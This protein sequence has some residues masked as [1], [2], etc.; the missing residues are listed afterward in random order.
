MARIK[1]L[2][3]GS[4]GDYRESTDEIEWV[5]LDQ[6]NCKV[7]IKANIEGMGRCY[8]KSNLGIAAS[9]IY[10]EMAGRISLN[11]AKTRLKSDYFDRI[12]AIQVLE[13]IDPKK[14]PDVVREMYRISK[15]GALWNISVPHGLSLNYV[16][17]PT[18][19][20]HF[21]DRTFDYFVEGA[22]LRENG[23]IYGWGD[24]S[25]AHSTPPEMDGVMSIHFHLRVVKTKT[26][27][28]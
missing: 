1:A 13:H 15:D 25:L 16:T 19:C 28:E 18:H 10:N 9:E 21:S 14:F 4:G 23:K 20:M 2:N 22:D 8:V 7:D 24:I 12:D 6:G 11:V 26:P 27:K 5:N 17:D 3:L